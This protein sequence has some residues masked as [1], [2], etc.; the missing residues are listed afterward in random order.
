MKIELKEIIVREI[1][2]G[3]EDKGI[4]GVTAYG[5]KLDVRP[6][7][8]REFIYDNKERDA[9]IETVRRGF[10]LNVMYWVKRD[11]GSFEVLDGQQRTLSLCQYLSGDFSV[12]HPSCGDLPGAIMYAHSLTDTQYDQIADY[13]LMVYQCEGTDQEKLDWFM[14]INIAG[15]RLMP[16]E[17]RNAIYAGPW[18]SDAKLSFSKPNCAAQRIAKDYVKGKVNR[19]DYLETAIDW[20]SDGQIEG[21]MAEHKEQ[22]TAA[23]LWRYFQEVITWVSQIFPHYRNEMKGVD[24]GSLFR[25]HKEETLDPNRLELKIAESMMDDEVQKKSGIYDFILNGNERVLNLRSFSKNQK[26]EVYERQGGICA[27]CGER[28]DFEEME[29][30]HITPWHLGGK[31]TLDN[32]QMLCMECNRRKSGK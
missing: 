27:I 17:L 6:P 14:T 12:N 2:E 24:W 29:G 30:D 15:E 22:P 19:Q 18:L 7:Y 8:Q 21:Y 9:V 1:F 4:E 23:E 26:R 11:D 13:K 16:Q 32:C 5:G 28:F 10:P 3:Y 25:M 31:T 20:I